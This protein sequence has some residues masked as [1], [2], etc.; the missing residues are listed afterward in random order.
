[1]KVI[2]TTLLLFLA[3]SL[4]QP[5]A[6]QEGDYL[7]FIHDNTIWRW[8]ADEELVQIGEKFPNR[9]ATAKL[10][11]TAE[12]LLVVTYREDIRKLIEAECPCGGTIPTGEEYWALDLQSGETFP[13]F[14]QPE[15]VEDD[16]EVKYVGSPLWSPDGTK[17]AWAQNLEYS[18]I[19]VY[20]LTTEEASV[21]IEGV[22]AQTLVSNLTY[23]STW[24]ETGIWVT[25]VDYSENYKPIPAGVAIYDLSG[26]IVAEIPPY[27]ELAGL[28][29]YQD[30]ETYLDYEYG[31]HY[32]FQE[33]GRDVFL[34]HSLT[35]W[36]LLDV[37]TG[38]VE[39][40]NDG[41]LWQ[42]A[43]GAEETSARVSP[44]IMDDASLPSYNVYIPENIFVTKLSNLNFF[45]STT[46]RTLVT[47]VEGNRVTIARIPQEG[48]QATITLPWRPDGTIGRQ[49]GYQLRR[50]VGALLAGIRC[51]GSNLPFRIP[52]ASPQYNLSHPAHVLGEVANSI[53]Q[54][55][56]RNAGLL[57][58]IPGGDSF[59]VIDGPRCNDGIAWY[60]VRYNEIEGWTAEGEDF[61]YYLAPGCTKENC[62]AYG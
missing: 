51:S 46:G 30:N 19:H 58:S 5:V 28:P 62:L 27:H 53:R 60:K 50:G 16:S 29:D 13:V 9:I 2:F 21:A 12:N 23:L 31:N 24:T 10:S 59:A 41:I 47:N 49:S 17:I 34:T 32:I 18:D 39:P 55:P 36:Q 57:G 14:Q 8:E 15:V 33:E 11:P 38:E 26:D 54:D 45:F 3:L 43:L 20:D 1:V 48:G 40:L 44:G 35:G 25:Q 52:T 56:N 22:Q 7:Y 61:E 4:A 6:A 42:I 37:R